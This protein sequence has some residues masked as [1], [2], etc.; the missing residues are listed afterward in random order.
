MTGR[1]LHQHSG[2]DL[3]EGGAAAIAY[4]RMQSENMSD[5]ERSEIR[6]SLLEYCELDT[7]AMVMLYEGWRDMLSR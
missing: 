1:N 7:L 5:Y 6:Q 2:L 4:A 3:N